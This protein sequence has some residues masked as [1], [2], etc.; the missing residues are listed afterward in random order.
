MSD[1]AVPK[2][3]SAVESSLTLSLCT[4]RPSSRETGTKEYVL[5]AIFLKEDKKET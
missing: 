1:G 4:L 3:E 2:V 5:F